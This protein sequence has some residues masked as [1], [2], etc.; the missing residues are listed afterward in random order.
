MPRVFNDG[1]NPMRERGFDL[2][3]N[4]KL[5]GLVLPDVLPNGAPPPQQINIVVNW[6]EELKQRV[7]VK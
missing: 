3:P 4:G 5:L 2:M 1:V 7:P 6:F